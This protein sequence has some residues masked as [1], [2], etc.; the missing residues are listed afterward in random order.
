MLSQT[1]TYFLFTNLVFGLKKQNSFFKFKLNSKIKKWFK[2]KVWFF[3]I[4]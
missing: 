4:L 2:L 1:F 3:Q